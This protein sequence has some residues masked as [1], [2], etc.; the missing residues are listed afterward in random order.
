MDINM[1]KKSIQDNLSAYINNLTYAYPQ[2]FRWGAGF[3]KT[4]V[5]LVSTGCLL[6]GGSQQVKPQISNALS[7]QSGDVVTASVNLNNQGRTIPWSFLGFSFEH[8]DIQRFGGNTS[9]ATNPAFIQLLKN[10]GNNNNGPVMLRFGGNSTDV[11]WWNPNG[12]PKPPGIVYDI[13]SADLSII[14]SVIKRTNSKVIFGLNFGQNNPSIAVDLAKATLSGLPA[15]KVY[16]FEL[17]NEP[18]YYTTHSYYINSLT[19]S[20][21][22]VRPS[23]YSLSPYLAEFANYST[24]LKNSF[25][26]LPPLSGP[27]FT[28]SQWMQYLPTFLAEQAPMVNSIT[29]HRYPL[30]ACG[31]QPGSPNYP[32]ITQLLADKSS[33]NL[34]QGIVPFVQVASDYNR[35]M[36]I[37]EINSVACGGA[38]GVSNSFASA[39]WGID[40]MFNMANTGLR[41]MQFHTTSGGYYSPFKFIKS[42]DSNGKSVYKPTV[43]PLYYGMLV[44]AKAASNQARLVAVT[45]Q[46]NSNVKV[47]A[48]IDNQNVLRVVAIN[49][50][51]NAKGNA[52]IQ[53]SSLRSIGS[54]VRLTASNATAITGI[55]LGGQTFDGTVDGQIL[56]NI[57]STL[58]TPSNGIYTFSLPA[59]SA[60]MLTINP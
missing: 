28:S 60:A 53:L 2:Q 36:W 18:D 55:N 1:F 56:G 49:K 13:T 32:T 51:L 57:D 46:T 12:L 3:L 15:G 19:G 41:G 5:A 17:G 50:D 29:Y 38:D 27:V 25:S 39:L 24:T 11:S 35:S 33:F 44:F 47:W 48:T 43:Y 52:K 37:S 7:L 9:S 40:I 42:I 26:T 30:H 6:L 59:S 45:S 8:G 16:S 21:E 31:I 58:V 22:Y 14:S 20:Q 23:T 34:A 10:F 4:S 54:L